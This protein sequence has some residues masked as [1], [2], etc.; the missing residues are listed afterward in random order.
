MLEAQVNCTGQYSTATAVAVLDG[1]AY[2]WANSMAN[3]L[4]IHN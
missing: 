2:S 3:Q 1:P 4:H